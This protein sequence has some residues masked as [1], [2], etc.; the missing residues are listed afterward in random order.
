MPMKS[1]LLISSISLLA[2]AHS[3]CNQQ[4][5]ALVVKGT[6][7]HS[8][9]NKLKSLQF[10]TIDE[11]PVLSGINRDQNTLEIHPLGH[12]DQKTVI[13]L[14]SIDPGLGKIGKGQ[15][16][17]HNLDSI[18]FNL[19]FK[20]PHF[21]NVVLLVN[22]DG[23]VQNSWTVDVAL[24]GGISNYALFGNSYSPLCYRQDKIYVPAFRRDLNAINKKEDRE[25]YYEPPQ[26][27]VLDLKTGVAVNSGGK[28]PA[29]YRGEGYYCD[30]QIRRSFAEN[31]RLYS[32]GFSDSLYL[33]DGEGNHTP[34]NAK[35]RYFK[36]YSP[37]DTIRMKDIT[38]LKEYTIS[39]ARYGK[40][41]YDP[42]RKLY[43]R[44]VLH[45]LTYEN[46]DGTLNQ[47]TDKPWSLM[48]LDSRFNVLDEFIFD[49]KEQLV[50]TGITAQGMLI[51]NTPTDSERAENTYSFTIFNYES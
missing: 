1:F 36:R 7:S 21:R 10:F 4:D 49:A 43:Y 33:F 9:S 8:F 17:V 42:Y 22:R 6:T 31:G 26:D 37:C 47:L 29:L 2:I 3:A 40:V 14:D 46:E 35:S 24:Q 45:E 30:V 39:A 51:S 19:S 20:S 5:G 32:F 23:M 34:L 18:F 13:P 11:K 25:I 15:F 41:L 12:A 50:L 16:F 38:Y 27:I 44:A 48:V 28:T